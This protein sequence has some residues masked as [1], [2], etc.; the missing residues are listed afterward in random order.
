VNL[1]QTPGISSARALHLQL[2]VRVRNLARGVPRCPNM[3]AALAAAVVVLLYS[4]CVLS[5]VAAEDEWLVAA[6]AGSV[7]VAC[8]VQECASEQPASRVVLVVLRRVLVDQAMFTIIVNG[9][10]APVLATP[11]NGI[12]PIPP[13]VSEVP[14][15]VRAAAHV[16]VQVDLQPVSSVSNVAT[17]YFDGYS[18]NG[19]PCGGTR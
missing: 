18:P 13:S 7:R 4:V 11:D 16:R 6:G 10:V 2:L 5:I 19:R 12:A 9:T 14:I 17:A 1:V 3:R 15:M 8:G